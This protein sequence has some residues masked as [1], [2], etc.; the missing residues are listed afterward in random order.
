MLLQ[1]KPL[2]GR[3]LLWAPSLTQCH[4]TRP[5]YH[6]RILRRG[7]EEHSINLHLS[8]RQVR[9]V[10]RE[11]L[12]PE[13]YDAHCIMGRGSA[14]CTTNVRRT[15][16]DT[17]SCFR[18]NKTKLAQGSENIVGPSPFTPQTHKK[19]FS[20]K[21]NSF[22]SM[23]IEA[24]YI[25]EKFVDLR[26]YFIFNVVFNVLGTCFNKPLTVFRPRQHVN[27]RYLRNSAS[28]RPKDDVK[29]T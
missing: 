24:V 12:Q 26:R 18:A 16:R 28:R 2:A 21:N 9:G 29:A 23:Q 1:S 11:G 15:R 17:G 19:P 6:T 14:V 22:D 10:H 20:I 13:R 4:V 25:I 3:W 5:S 8:D 7:G 27:L